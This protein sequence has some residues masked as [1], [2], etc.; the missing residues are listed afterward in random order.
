MRSRTFTLVAIMALALGIGAGT[1]V[2]S[3]VDRILFRSLPYPRA[4]RLVSLGMVAPIVPQEFMLGYDYLDWRDGQTAF[5]SLGSWVAGVRDCDL[6]DTK[7]L[8]LRCARVDSTLL[9]TLGTEPVVG[10]NFTRQ[11]ETPN[12]PKTAIISDGLWRSRFAGN[13]GAVGKTMRLDGQPVTIA[14]VLPRQFELPTLEAVDILV[15]QV[16]DEPE[17]RS[18]RLAILLVAVGRLKPGVSAA[19]A[20]AELHPLFEKSLEAVTMSFRKDVKLRVRPLRDRQIQDSRLASWVLLGSVLAVLLI[21]CANVA[22]L[23]LA[24]AATHEREFAVRAALGADRGRL[25]RQALTES[26]LLALM[27]GGAGCA[28]AFAL[29]RFFVEIA[30]EGIPRLHQAGLDARVLLFALLLSLACGVL[31]GLAIAFQTPRME[32]LGAGRSLPGGHHRF[33]QS[34]VAVQICVSL[35]LLAGAGLLLRSLWNLENQPLGIRAEN[36]VTATVTLGRTAYPEPAQRLAIF[37]EMERRLRGIPGAADVALA[38]SLPPAGNSMGSMLYAAI[39]VRGRPRF[40]NG[41]GGPVEWRWVTPR[42]FSVLGIPILQGRTFQE[43]DRDPSRNVVILSDTLARRMF[44]GENPLGQQIR[45]GRQGEWLTVVGVAANVKNNGLI[46]RDHPEYYVPRKHSPV[47]VT[48][49]A[50]AIIRAATT[51]QAMARSVRAE[52]ATLDA[53]LPVTIETME[54]R[55]GKFAER[56]RFNALLLA[57]FASLGV[58]LAAIGLYGVISFLVEQRTPEIGVRMA[59]GATPGA[60]AR[61]VLQQAAVWTTAGAALGVIGSLVAVRLLEHLLF[62]VSAKDPWT[63]AA[64]VAVLLGVA[65]AA[66]WIPS[67]RAAHMD[68]MRVLR[69]E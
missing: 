64:A 44:P 48:A 63:F 40:T 24:R 56:P 37:E 28:L 13:P 38:E 5:E 41:T 69:R 6:N 60:I 68:P 53:T 65:F 19:Q 26:T 57:I 20:E 62:Q 17:Q 29:L 34:L 15:P 31:F 8:R 39:D 46:E 3:V 36:V 7:P 4:D 1:A 18:R 10:R 30:P 59:L 2:F 49:G 27:G 21:A 16:L 35:V 25:V 11:E 50:T 58:L 51:P 61:M 55:V 33:R 43:E 45:P 22:N 54:Q 67:R 66:A 42:Y 12:A 47:N 9:R 14:G 23:L 32:T 52:I